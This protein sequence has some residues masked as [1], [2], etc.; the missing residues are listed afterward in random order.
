VATVSGIAID[1]V[2][3]TTLSGT[4]ISKYDNIGSASSNVN[5]FQIDK[6]TATG[7]IIFNFAFYEHGTYTIV[8]SGNPIVLQKI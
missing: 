8:G 6:A 7:S 2:I 1:A 5:Y 4:T 3:T